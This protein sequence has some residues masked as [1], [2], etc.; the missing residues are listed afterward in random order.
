MS[1]G[2]YTIFFQCSPSISDEDLMK[3]IAEAFGSLSK[4]RVFTVTQY[5]TQGW[6]YVSI[7]AQETLTPKRYS[8]DRLVTWFY[9][10]S[11]LMRFYHFPTAGVPGWISLPTLRQVLRQR[12]SSQRVTATASYPVHL[13]YRQRALLS[14]LGVGQGKEW[15]GFIDTIHRIHER[16]YYG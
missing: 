8:V 4:A 3:L 15:H 2:R 14:T 16:T 5:V 1:N 6:A 12:S 9:N 10:P 13:L 7:G 11:P